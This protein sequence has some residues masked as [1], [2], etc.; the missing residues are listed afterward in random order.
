MTQESLGE[1]ADLNPKYI[2]EVECMEKNHFR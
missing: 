1:M 2:G